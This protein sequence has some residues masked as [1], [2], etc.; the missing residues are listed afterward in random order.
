MKTVL[1]LSEGFYNLRGA[2]TVRGVLPIGTH[3]SLVRRKSGGFILLDAI[4]LDPEAR[5]FVDDLTGRGEA[6]E[7]VLH[8]H[9]FHTLFVRSAHSLFPRAKLYGTSRH[10]RLAPELPWEP[11]RT[12]DPALH[13]LFAEEL[14]FSVPR[15]V[16][17]IPANENLH[18]S[19]VLAFHPASRTL[20]VDDTLN[21]VRLPLPFSLFK[22]DLL[23][24]HPTLSRVLERRAGAVRD[25]RAWTRELAERVRTI[26][27]VCAAHTATL[28][29]RQAGGP[30]V[31]QRVEAAI[32]KVEPKLAAHEARFG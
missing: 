13:Q 12:E 19:S 6:I 23:G 29:G 7:A 28:V 5:R 32:R 14:D 9:P 31:S 30:S 8:L 16:D 2:L 22:K 15:G 11:L 21:Y 1:D 10:A 20:H 27:N 25:F 26:D 3:A 24:L 18:F 4:E 17:F